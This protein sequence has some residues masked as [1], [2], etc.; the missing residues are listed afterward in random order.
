MGEVE[1]VEQGAFLVQ[2]SC[3]GVEVFG[4][5]TGEEPTGEASRRTLVIVDGEDHSVAHPVVEAPVA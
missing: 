4:S 5:V 2:L 1:A 3:G